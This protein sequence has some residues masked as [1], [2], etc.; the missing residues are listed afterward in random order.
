MQNFNSLASTHQTDVAYFWTFFKEN[1]RIFQKIEKWISKNSE[2]EYAVLSF[3]Y[4]SICMSNFST[5][6]STQTDLDFFWQFFKFISEFFRRTLKRISKKFKFEYVVWRCN[7]QSMFMQNFKSLVSTQTELDKF[8][9]IFQVNFR[10]LTALEN[11]KTCDFPWKCVRIDIR[12][13]VLFSILSTNE[14]WIVLVSLAKK[15]LL[16]IFTL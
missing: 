15:K 7:K 6:A 2:S 11:F 13:F 1:F 4:Q 8:F 14:T 12:Y 9:T 10:I 3:N 16:Q 5:P